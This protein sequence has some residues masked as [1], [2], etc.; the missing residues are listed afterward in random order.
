M[1]LSAEVEKLGDEVAEVAL[2]CEYC[3]RF[4]VQV[5]ALFGADL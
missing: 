1:T 5:C 3:S 2:N 4:L